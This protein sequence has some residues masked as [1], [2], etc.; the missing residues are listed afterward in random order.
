MEFLL[1]GVVALLFVLAIFD[2]SVGVSNDAVNFLNSAVGSRAATFKR[3]V[4]VAAVGVFLGACLSNGMMEIARHGI[5]QPEYFSFYDIIAICMT[6]M[7]ADVILLDIYN[8]LGLP[9][10]TTVS[11]VFELLGATF[12][13]AFV[14]MMSDPVSAVTFSEYLNTDKAL[15]VIIGIFM[16]VGIAFVV[17]VVVQW[18][19]RAIFSFNYKK[20]LS[21]KIGIFGGVA[22]TT[23]VYFLLIKGIKDLTLSTPELNMWMA[24]NTGL[25]IGGCFVF[26]TILMQILHFCKVNIFKVVVLLGTF[27]LA[28]AFAGNDLVNFLGVPLAGYDSWVDYTAN[29]GGD[30][31]GYMMDSLNGPAQTP[32]YFLLGAG[33][34]MVIALAT[35]RKAHKVIETEVSLGRQDSG[36][37]MFGSSRVARRMVASS[38]SIAK[39]IDKRIPAG[40]RSWMSKRFDSNEAILADGA[41]FDLVRASVNLVVASALIALGTSLKLPLSTT[42]VT[43]MVAMATSL[44]D[45]AWGRESAVFRITGVI[46]VVGGWFLTAAVAFIG[47]ALVVTVL[48]FGGIEEVGIPLMIIAAFV[49]IGLLIR[50][51][52]KFSK[53]QEEEQGST[54]FTTL[55]KSKDNEETRALLVTFIGDNLKRFL[56][57]ASSAYTHATTGFTQDNPKLL[58]A[59][60]RALVNE[61]QLLKGDRRRE[62]LIL[63]KLDP[64]TALEMSSPFYIANNSVLSMSYNLRR[65]T[66]SCNEHVQNRFLPLSEKDAVAYAEVRERILDLI[67]AT[68]AEI[69]TPNPD[70]IK[71]LRAQCYSVRDQISK[72]SREVINEIHTGHEKNMTVSYVYLNM[73][74]E[75]REIASS[76][77]KL[78]RAY[79]KLALPMVSGPEAFDDEEKDEI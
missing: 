43:F 44:A 18:I 47:A 1:I 58:A 64:M 6:V 69:D 22:S 21:W 67:H 30:M 32:I 52:R 23:I 57:R 78:L 33:I 71:E 46:S 7:V 70:E 55:L 53:K 60:H 10:S 13:V 45:R 35:S 56:N 2:L 28:M 74:Q 40:V 19:A 36:D 39:W 63:R 62:S 48:H 37:E 20:G 42:Y 29:G 61:K 25:L 75:T 79:R 27:S 12:A 8:T 38:L 65:I 16:S 54:L 68:I 26:F 59:A 15:S 41:S 14:K 76:L 17:G 24:E 50:S 5:F 66:E 11:M 34:I 9:T 3:V 72:M 49:A 77:H 4:C 73:L 51:S 31:T